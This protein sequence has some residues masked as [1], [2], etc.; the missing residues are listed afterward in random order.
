VS[1]T[2]LKP[3]YINGQLQPRQ[4][5]PLALS[6]DHRAVNGVDGGMFITTL[7]RLLGDIRLLVL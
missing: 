5:L 4:M 1:K 6:Y 3:I 7:A 2:Q